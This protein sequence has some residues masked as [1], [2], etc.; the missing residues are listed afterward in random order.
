[1]QTPEYMGCVALFIA[2]VSIGL[3]IGSAF[4]RTKPAAMS[5]IGLVFA[6]A[7]VFLSSRCRHE[8]PEGIG[9]R[10]FATAAYALGIVSIIS[11]IVASA[12]NG[13]Y[14][15]FGCVVDNSQHEMGRACKYIKA[16]LGISDSDIGAIFM[17]LL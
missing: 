2:V 11:C 3:C 4:V 5:I 7:A 1:M 6:I 17:N 15:A 14:S 10:A 16:N 8:I 13:L 12:C 9:M